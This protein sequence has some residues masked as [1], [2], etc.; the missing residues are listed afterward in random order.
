M[1]VTYVKAV[2]KATSE[3]GSAGRITPSSEFS[4]SS[5][6]AIAEA[7]ELELNELEWAASSPCLF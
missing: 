5:C 4:L 2:N 1:G 7:W 6:V 3:Q